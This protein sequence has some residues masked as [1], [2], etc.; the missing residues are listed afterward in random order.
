MYS[1][2]PSKNIILCRIWTKL[3]K[4]RII[5]V[6]E[7]V[8]VQ[9]SIDFLH[10][11]RWRQRFRH[12]F[13]LLK[14][15][16]NL[17]WKIILIHIFNF[18]IFLRVKGDCGRPES[19]EKR[20][21]KQAQLA[22]PEKS[23]RDKNYVDGWNSSIQ[24]KQIKHNKNLKKHFHEITKFWCLKFLDNKHFEFIRPKDS[25]WSSKIVV[26]NVNVAPSAFQTE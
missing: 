17:V 4:L 9:I 20:W 8:K 1:C 12:H 22:M 19:I 18:H 15:A 6:K 5:F 21:I 24:S 23:G 13:F 10:T 3:I 14:K 16:G 25:K 7:T 26:L 11:W 2:I